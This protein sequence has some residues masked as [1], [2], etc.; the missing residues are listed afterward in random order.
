VAA[1]FVRIALALTLNI[2]FCSARF[3]FPLLP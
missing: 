1:M 2:H 3:T